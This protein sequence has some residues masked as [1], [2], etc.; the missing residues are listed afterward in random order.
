MPTV[1]A[2]IPTYNRAHLISEALESALR[3][4]R[5]PDEIIVV[6]D[7][8]TDDTKRVVEQ[9]GTDVRYIYQKNSG[10]AAARNQ[11]LRVATGDIIAFLDSDDLWVSQKIEIQLDFL[12]RHPEVGGLFGDM[13]NAFGAVDN[14]TPEIKNQELHDYLVAHASDLGDLFE[15][16]I[17]ENV[18]P[19]PTVMLRRSVVERIGFFKESL[20]VAEDLDY[21]LRAVAACRW[22]FI[23]QV[24]LIRRRH[25]SNLISDSARRKVSTIEVLSTTGVHLAHSRPRAKLLIEQKVRQLHYDVGS[26]F[27]KE[28]DFTQA[29]SHLKM[30]WPTRSNIVAGAL[31][32]LVAGTLSLFTTQ[33]SVAPKR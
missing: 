22:G 19:T 25:D 12:A 29:F 17:I 31:K 7:G 10:P 33:Q 13:S 9:Y 15:W 2:I 32:L 16:L 30:S 11:G 28:S 3:Q 4:S 5:R 26:K 23:N 6:D 14:L 1:T 18:I 27:L 24:L 21:W 20:I 8:S